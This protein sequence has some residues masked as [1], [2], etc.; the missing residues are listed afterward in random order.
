MKKPSEIFIPKQ[1]NLNLLGFEQ[2]KIFQNLIFIASIEDIAAMK[3]LAIAQRGKR[4]DF[5]D[6]YHLIKLFGLKKILSWAKEKYPTYQ[7]LIF[8][9]GL[10]YF[11][12]AEKEERSTPTWD[13]IKKEIIAEVKKYQRL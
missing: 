6:I 8:L 11:E 1:E 10:T 4:R 3:A 9:K 13:Q 12:D 2:K 5:I 7:D